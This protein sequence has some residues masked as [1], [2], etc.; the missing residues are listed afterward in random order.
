[1]F[2]RVR[3]SFYCCHIYVYACIFTSSSCRRRASYAAAASWTLVSINTRSSASH[4]SFTRT[5]RVQPRAPPPRQPA[6]AARGVPATTSAAGPR[7]PPPRQPAAAAR[8]VPAT[9]SAAG[10]LGTLPAAA[11]SSPGMAAIIYRESPPRLPCSARV[12]HREE[13]LFLVLPPQP[14]FFKIK[15]IFLRSGTQESRRLMEASYGSISAQNGADALSPDAGRRR[16]APSCLLC[17]RVCS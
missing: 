12:S 9:T 8:G 2:E 13:I 17:V 1:M 14:H 10:L 4:S 11:S 3:D 6:A 5:V 7:A 16:C 15:Q